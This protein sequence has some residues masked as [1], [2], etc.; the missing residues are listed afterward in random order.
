MVNNEILTQRA[1]GQMRRVR[2]VSS[3]LWLRDLKRPDCCMGKRIGIMLTRGILFGGAS[4]IIF[5]ALGIVGCSREIKTHPSLDKRIENVEN[6]LRRLESTQQ[7]Q[8]QS[9][10]DGARTNNG[11]Y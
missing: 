6:E 4:A 10:D 1:Y 7:E 9:M 3:V 11:E 8:G 5:F 2:D